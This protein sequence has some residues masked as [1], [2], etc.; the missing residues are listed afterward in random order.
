M[1]NK[2]SHREVIR[3]PVSDSNIEA[4]R[5]EVRQKERNLVVNGDKECRGPN[6]LPSK[7]ASRDLSIKPLEHQ[8]VGAN[9]P[10]YA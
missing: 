6:F 10:I 1:L 5:K 8:C 9:E 7:K 2:L 4:Y 3:L